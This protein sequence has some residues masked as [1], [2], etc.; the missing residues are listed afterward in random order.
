[1]KNNLRLL[2]A[3]LVLGWTSASA[4]TYVSERYGFRVSYDPQWTVDENEMFGVRFVVE[5]GI[6]LSVKRPSARSSQSMAAYCDRQLKS[7][8]D[9]KATTD[10]DGMAGET[11]C[12]ITHPN[13]MKAYTEVVF[14]KKGQAIYSA[15]LFVDDSKP[16]KIEK[17]RQRF[18]DFL[19]GIQLH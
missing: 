8:N 14:V 2:L 4:E 19:G 18:R 11:G 13:W 12:R 10:V 16:G 17:S 9:P 5:P 7:A 1:M 6:F 3:V 15:H